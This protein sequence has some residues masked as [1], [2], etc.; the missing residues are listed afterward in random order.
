MDSNGTYEKMDMLAQDMDGDNEFNMLTDRVFV[1]ILNDR[2]QWRGTIFIIDF[3]YVA[4]ETGLPDAGD[5]YQVSFKRPFFLNDS[6]VFKINPEIEMDNEEFKNSWENIKVVPNPYI[7]TNDMEPAVSNI[8]LNQRRRILFTNIPAQCT[9]KIFTS[10]AVLVD[11]I[12]VEN[13]PNE[14]IVHW[15]LLSKEG[16]EIAAGIYFYHIKATETGDEK[17]GKFAIIK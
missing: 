6:L 17:M 4:D 7:A 9:I 3:Q 16:L 12:D 15:D 13:S 8:F 1:G 10:S 2:G 14:G 11:Q 5:S